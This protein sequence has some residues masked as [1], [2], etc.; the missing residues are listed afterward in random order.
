MNVTREMIQELRTEVAAAVAEI[1]ARHGLTQP[2]IKSVYGPSAK[3]TLEA[4][5]ETLGEGG[6]NLTSREADEYE[7]YG[8]TMGLTAG[9]L[10]KEFTYG[11]KR[12]VFTGINLG[13]PKFPLCAREVG[14]KQGQFKLGRTAVE[15][16]NAAVGK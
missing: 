16:V 5:L 8:E 14:G 15:A 4:Q 3:L 10:G 6:V 12:Y 7:R 13:R 1:Y 2:T 11:G 9:A